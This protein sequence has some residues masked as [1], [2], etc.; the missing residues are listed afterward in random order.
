MILTL[1]AKAFKK[2]IVTY[3]ADVRCENVH[4]TVSIQDFITLAHTTFQMFYICYFLE[5]EYKFVN[6]LI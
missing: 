2:R 6:K 3:S 5:K 1:T 4:T